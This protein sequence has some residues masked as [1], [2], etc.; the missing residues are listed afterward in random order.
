MMV[1]NEVEID[2]NDLWGGFGICSGF[3]RIME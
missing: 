2:W 1:V 3:G